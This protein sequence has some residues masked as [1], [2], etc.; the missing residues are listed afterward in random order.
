M[1]FVSDIV[2]IYINI[3]FSFK[4]FLR[5][6]ALMNA[7]AICIERIWEGLAIIYW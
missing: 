7:A 3:I 2:N 5:I 1:L 4:L 6:M